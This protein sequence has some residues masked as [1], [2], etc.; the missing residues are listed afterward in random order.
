M[1]WPQ[2]NDVYTN[3]VNS[4]EITRKRLLIETLESILGNAHQLFMMDDTSG[5]LKLLNL[6][7]TSTGS[8]SIATTVPKATIDPASHG[9]GGR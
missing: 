2:F 4:K 9:C 3:Y 7:G 5:A 6:N 8:Q 1:K